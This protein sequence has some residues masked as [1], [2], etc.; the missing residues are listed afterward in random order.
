MVTMYPDSLTQIEA[1]LHAHSARQLDIRRAAVINEARDLGLTWQQIAE[2]IEMTRKG[3]RELLARVAS[4]EDEAPSPSEPSA[5][6]SP[7]PTHPTVTFIPLEDF[8]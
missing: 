1:K 8:E 3:V 6:L 7:S 5:P 2:G 4:Y